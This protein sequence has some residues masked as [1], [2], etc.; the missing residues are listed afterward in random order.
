MDLNTLTDS[1]KRIRPTIEALLWFRA[2]VFENLASL[3]HLERFKARL[4]FS[5]PALFF[6]RYLFNKF[7]VCEEEDE[8]LGFAILRFGRIRSL[9]VSLNYH[10]IGIGSKLLSKMCLDS[11]SKHILVKP[12]KSAE[13]FYLKNGF[14][15]FG[16]FMIKS[17]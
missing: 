4:G 15:R 5:I 12:V 1:L 17:K 2:I 10:G 13:G 3:T 8:V 11:K 6:S 9:F 16:R 7:Y 14:E